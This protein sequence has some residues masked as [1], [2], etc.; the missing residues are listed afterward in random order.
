[1]ARAFPML[2][3]EHSFD[4]AWASPTEHSRCPV[5]REPGLVQ[6]SGWWSVFVKLRPDLVEWRYRTTADLRCVVLSRA[7]FRAVIVR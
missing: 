3:S 6:Q 2:C 7:P 4:H 1:M 5:C